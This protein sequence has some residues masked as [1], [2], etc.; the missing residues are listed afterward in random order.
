MHWLVCL[1]RVEMIVKLCPS[2]GL[3]GSQEPPHRP[4]TLLHPITLLRV[5][6]PSIHLNMPRPFYLHF[7][8]RHLSLL[9]S[10]PRKS[11][12]KKERKNSATIATRSGATLTD[13]LVSFCFF[14][15]QRML[16]RRWVHQLI[17]ISQMLLRRP[18]SLVISPV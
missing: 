1:K 7:Y 12:V 18:L 13:A 2:L 3:S 11:F 17:L 5:P 8:Q 16:T 6:L 15:E 4:F 10:F 9:S 14:W